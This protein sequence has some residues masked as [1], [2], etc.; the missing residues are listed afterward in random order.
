MKKIAILSL[1]LVA[2]SGTAGLGLSALHEYTSNMQT[3][4]LSTPDNIPADSGFVIPDYV[5]D[6]AQFTAFAPTLD[7]PEQSL[8][9]VLAPV[10]TAALGDT[11]IEPVT[12]APAPITPAVRAAV[13]APGAVMGPSTKA[14]MPKPATPTYAAEVQSFAHTPDA[15]T[16]IDYIIG[17]Y[18]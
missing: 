16:R 10:E 1:S 13:V 9:P 4:A 5:P 17:V 3:S 8:A 11:A 7:A 15:A 14:R 6:A 18:R 2:I 12:A